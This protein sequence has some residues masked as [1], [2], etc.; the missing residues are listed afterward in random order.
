LEFILG[1]ISVPMKLLRL[2]SLVSLCFWGAAVSVSA[3]IAV[4][5]SAFSSGGTIPAQFT[6]KG[7]NHNPPLQFQ[8]IPK[9]A[10][11]LVLMMDDPD[12]PGGTFNHWLIWNLDSTTSQ[13]GERSEPTERCKEQMTLATS[14]MAVPAR[15]PAPIAITFASLPSIECSS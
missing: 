14:A 10:K 2:L 8:G 13:I 4:T 6:C 3:Q 1:L 9:T 15:L 12:A 5:S 7:A 11:S